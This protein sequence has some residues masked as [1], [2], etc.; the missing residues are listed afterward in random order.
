MLKP[1]SFQ[2]RKKCFEQYKY[3]KL[4]SHKI[5]LNWLSGSEFCLFRIAPFWHSAL[6]LYMFFQFPKCIPLLILPSLLLYWRIYCMNLNSVA[7][8]TL[9]NR[10]HCWAL[11]QVSLTFQKLE[12][13]S[14]DVTPCSPVVQFSSAGLHSFKSQERAPFIVT[15]MRTSY[16]KFQVRLLC[17][18]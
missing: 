7:N 15:I 6:F 18:H 13:S 16:P 17:I 12:H 1:V 2:N 11:V 8:K 9:I 4:E 14:S 5:K 3:S 10:V